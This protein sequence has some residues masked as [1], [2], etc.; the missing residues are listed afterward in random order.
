[1]KNIYQNAIFNNLKKVPRINLNN[2]TAL[3][4]LNQ[5][6]S[7]DIE[8]SKNRISLFKKLKSIIL[9]ILLR[10][11]I[12]KD[13]LRTLSNL[14]L[15]LLKQFLIK[16]F[17]LDASIGLTS[18]LLNSLSNHL[19]IKRFEENIKFVFLKGIRFLQKVFNCNLYPFLR[20]FL[21]KDFFHFQEHKKIEYAFY[22]YYFGHLMAQTQQPIES[23]FRPRYFIP[24]NRKNQ[25]S[26]IPKT[27][28]K[29]YINLVKLSQF[30]TQ[31]LLFY[32]QNYYETEIKSMI[33]LK[34]VQMVSE[35]E[36]VYFAKGETGITGFM[37]EK[38]GT[39]SRSKLVWSLDEARNASQE[40]VKI[41]K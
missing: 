38:F 32:L 40:L 11:P 24:K 22:G 23:F 18:T 8:I 34:T 9:K 27:I 41:L 29:M 1:M 6:N 7:F 4:F 28:S 10:K 26:L 33:L 19:R 13:D 14:E 25:L 36:E 35:W 2:S 39:S 3:N 5:L 37:S 21:H 12:G 15:S 30:F 16:K 20:D 17:S 31:D